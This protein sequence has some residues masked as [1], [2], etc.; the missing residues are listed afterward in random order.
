M[1]RF[2]NTER[3]ITID[4]A[5]FSA[6]VVIDKDKVVRAPPI[7]EFMLGWSSKEV[8]RYGASKGWTI[9]IKETE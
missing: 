2:K 5:H 8:S 7:V 3:V 9:Q 4:S 1:F 6:E